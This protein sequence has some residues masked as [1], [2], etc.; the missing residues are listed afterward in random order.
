MKILKLTIVTCLLLSTGSLYAQTLKL[1]K[2]ILEPIQVSM[3]V[4][5]LLGRD[6]GVTILSNIILIPT[7][8][9]TGFE[10]KLQKCMNLMPT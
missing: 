7:T 10:K 1:S 8:S 3:S 6:V 9:L 4:E 5:K 2:S